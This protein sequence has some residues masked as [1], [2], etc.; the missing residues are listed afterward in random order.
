MPIV[1]SRRNFL[2][3]LSLA[4]AAGML[5]GGRSLAAEGPLETTTLRLRRA[6]SICVAP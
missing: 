2:A 3:G 6:P 5:G 1:H 4:G